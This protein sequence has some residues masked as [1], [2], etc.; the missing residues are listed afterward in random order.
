M[1]SSEHTQRTTLVKSIYLDIVGYSKRLIEVQVRLITVRDRITRSA[2]DALEVS[3]DDCVLT[4]LGDGL[5]IALSTASARFDIH[6]RLALEI[7]RTV[8]NHNEEVDES[9]RFELR[10]GIDE[11]TD[12]LI[13]DINGRPNVAGVGANMG[14]RIMNLA[15][16]G[17]ILVAQ[18]VHKQLFMREAYEGNFRELPLVEV[19]HGVRLQVF[20]Y[21]QQGFRGLN[22]SLPG[23]W[24]EVSSEQAKA[25]SHAPNQPAII[26]E[27]PRDTN[28]LATTTIDMAAGTSD[29]SGRSSGEQQIVET[30]GDLNKAVGNPNFADGL[31]FSGSLDDFQLLRLKLLATCW[32]QSLP[33]NALDNHEFNRLYLGRER[34][35]A[36]RP[37]LL[38]FLRILVNDSS[39]FVPGWYWQAAFEETTLERVILHLALTDSLSAVRQ[40]AFGLLSSAAVPVPEGAEQSIALVVTNDSAV[41]VRRAAVRYLG[42]VGDEGHLHIVGSALVDGDEAVSRQAKDSKFLILARN[43]PDRALKELLSDSGVSVEEILSELVPRID[44]VTSAT[45]T[46]ALENSNDAIRLITIKQLRRRGALTVESAS[47]HKEDKSDAVKAEAYRFVIE[48]D[49]PLE[50]EE[51]AFKV[52]DDPVRRWMSRSLVARRESIIDRNEIVLSYYR[53]FDLEQLLPMAQWKEWGGN[54]AYLAL[55]VDHFEQFGDKLR[56]DLQADFSA[57]ADDYYEQEL[58]ESRR[59]N[60]LTAGDGGLSQALGLFGSWNPSK[61]ITPEDSAKSSV[62]MRKSQYVRSA[63]AGL[64]H[65]GRDS[66]VEFGRK[67]LF[68]GDTDIRIEAVKVI[69]KF[70]TADDVT[71]LI[72]VATSSDALLQ[73]LAAEAALRLAADPFAVA[74][75][76]LETSDEILLSISV[77]DLIVRGD[78]ESAGSFLTPYLINPNDSVRARAMTFFFMRY[79]KT[80]LEALLSKYTKSATYYYDVVCSFDRALY[81]PARLASAYL[82]QLKKG[83]YGLLEASPD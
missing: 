40:A 70:G 47:R 17:Q 53:R 50:S 34:L 56:E 83:F 75:Q 21:I 4:H 18:S 63:L 22:C 5:F 28:V 42:H 7:L 67:F 68:D 64:A 79:E 27:S 69:R 25:T 54:D 14:A 82:N 15:D 71:N 52:P 33:D 12:D 37:E 8:A 9:E 2:L 3:N 26:S 39:G 38:M 74:A 30:V 51:I 41:E 65:N 24:L 61:K 45:L 58:A 13:T 6:L 19:K 62:D 29:V 59:I 16:G 77:A 66:D 49:V 1:F 32:L 76:F 60:G 23:K 72:S 36:T 80:E 46:S 35:E 55:T 31:R 43:A 11:S 73:E 81:C 20:Q 78:R 44:E 48:S 10:F 57:A